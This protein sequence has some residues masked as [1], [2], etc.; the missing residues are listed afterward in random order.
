ML[1][2]V[3]ACP[4]WSAA[5]KSSAVSVHPVVYLFPAAQLLIGLWGCGLVVFISPYIDR[6]EFAANQITTSVSWRFSSFFSLYRNLVRP[7]SSVLHIVVFN[8]Q[9]I[10]SYYYIL[11]KMLL[12]STYLETNCPSC[13]CFLLFLLKFWSCSQRSRSWLKSRAP[14]M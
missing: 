14:C 1:S 8:S 12:I 13:Y 10:G 4:R 9:C 2:M 5:V 6:W 7:V 11:N 3:E